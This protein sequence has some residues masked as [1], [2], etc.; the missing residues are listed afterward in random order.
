MRELEPKALHLLGKPSTR[1][2]DISL[3]WSKLS[4]GCAGQLLIGCGT[5]RNDVFEGTTIAK[6]SP[7]PQ[8]RTWR[9]GED[10]GNVLKGR[11]SVPG[12]VTGKPSVRTYKGFCQAK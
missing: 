9:V 10:P 1:E 8:L 11:V 5:S 2:L 12:G 7:T 3:L 6:V 4:E